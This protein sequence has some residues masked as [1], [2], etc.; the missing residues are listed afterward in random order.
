MKQQITQFHSDL[1]FKDGE[2]G[3]IPSVTS[4]LPHRHQTFEKQNAPKTKL[5][6][7]LL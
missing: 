3:T 7:D 6:H 4:P 2:D 5:T 1:A